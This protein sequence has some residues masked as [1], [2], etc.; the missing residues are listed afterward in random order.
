MS[1]PF[2]DYGE[3]AILF[4]G[5]I[6]WIHSIAFVGLHLLRLISSSFLALIGPFGK[7]L[8]TPQIDQNNCFDADLKQ[9]PI[10]HQFS[11]KFKLH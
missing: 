7:L 5:F 1:E 11:E 8:F 3:E 9:T 6:C 10:T 2:S 4:V